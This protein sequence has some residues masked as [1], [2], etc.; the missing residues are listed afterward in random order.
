MENIWSENFLNRRQQFWLKLK[1]ERPAETCEIRRN[2]T[3]IVL[4]QKLQMFHINGEPLD[5]TQRREC[6]VLD[7]FRAEKD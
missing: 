4:P 5:Q 6:Q 1:R 3:P 7:N 2:A